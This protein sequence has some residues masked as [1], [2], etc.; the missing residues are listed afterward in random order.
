MV[1]GGI[2]SILPDMDT[3]ESTVGKILFPISSRLEKIFGHRTFTHSLFFCLLLSIGLIP[4]FF[5]KSHW[6]YAVLL[7]Y[8][9]H[10]IIDC[11]NKTGVPFFWPN[12][13]YFVFP[14]SPRWRIQVGSLGE[15]ILCGVII[16]LTWAT[17]YLNGI[18][19]RSWMSAVLAS[20]ELA[21][22]EYRIHANTHQMS[23]K[24]KG[25]YTLSQ[26]T[27]NDEIF[28]VIDSDGNKTLIVKNQDNKLITV[29]ENPNTTIQAHK[30]VI[31]KDKPIEAKTNSFKFAG[32]RLGLISKYIDDK[33]YIS[34]NVIA[35]ERPRFLKMDLKPFSSGEFESIK[36]SAGTDE[37]D[38]SLELRDATLEQLKALERVGITGELVSRKIV[39]LT[40]AY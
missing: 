28:P 4:L 22:K 8:F 11:V 14:G 21:V 31:L 20:P 35:H 17:F 39:L 19:L 38:S 25:F 33:T 30:M 12:K 6:Y 16:L 3:K 24:V 36:I 27:V 37:Y 13:T 26:E 7:G 32:Q 2:S 15:Y 29:G 40:A 1:I 10:L 34:G 9:S 5:F 18:G 23:V